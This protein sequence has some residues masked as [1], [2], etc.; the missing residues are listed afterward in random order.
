[1]LR[2]AFALVAAAMCASV[3]SANYMRVVNLA[4]FVTATSPSAPFTNVVTL[5]PNTVYD[6]QSQ[7]SVTNYVVV[8]CPPA[9]AVK[10]AKVGEKAFLAYVTISDGNASSDIYVYDAVSGYTLGNLYAVPEEGYGSQLTLICVN[11]RVTA[12]YNNEA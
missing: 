1:M 9:K 10:N 5:K 6:Y 7:P 11:G 4:P 3:A 12:A 2:K 8:Q